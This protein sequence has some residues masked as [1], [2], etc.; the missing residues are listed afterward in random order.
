MALE[1]RAMF[2]SVTIREWQASTMDRNVAMKAEQDWDA[3]NRTMRVVKS[4][5][6]REHLLPIHRLAV[7]GREQHERMTLPGIQKGVQIL[8][9]KMFDDYAYT[10]SRIEDAFREE[11]KRFVE[12]Y[13]TIVKTAP[14][15]L[16]SAFKATDFPA[17]DEIASYFDYKVKFSPIPKGGNWLLDGVDAT[18]MMKLR[19]EIENENNEMFRQASEA[20]FTRGKHVLENLA[21]QAEDFKEGQPNGALLREATINSVKEMA[22]LIRAMNITG[23][24]ML[25]QIG[26]E[27][28][29]AFDHMEAR[30]LQ[31]S[32]T[33]RAE[34]LDL[35]KGILSKMNAAQQ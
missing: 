1:D 2:A 13:P 6:P 29:E 27:M 8:A 34:I 25:D 7:L 4:L 33:R 23:D 31:T 12:K 11:V 3:D 14:V 5:S 10:Q 32:A 30:Q 28:K 26:A 35:A 16:G 15:R 24:P 19:N 22:T 9:T 20:L 21:K 18:D 17:E